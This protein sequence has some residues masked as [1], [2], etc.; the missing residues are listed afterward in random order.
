VPRSAHVSSQDFTLYLLLALYLRPACVYSESHASGANL[1]SW[2]W[3]LRP[4]DFRAGIQRI[5]YSHMTW[6]PESCTI[7]LS[8]YDFV[9]ISALKIPFNHL[10][11]RIS[12]LVS[13]KTLEW[14]SRYDETMKKKTWVNVRYSTSIFESANTV[15]HTQIT[16]QVIAP[17]SSDT[18]TSLFGIPQR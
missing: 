6:E 14:I 4:R 9:N 18:R 8:F 3:A 5:Y 17:W 13:A 12:I 7:P 11:W 10:R 2:F 16:D 1:F 15:S